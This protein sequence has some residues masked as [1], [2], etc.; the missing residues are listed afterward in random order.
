[1]TSLG[2]PKLLLDS[3]TC[4][5][6]GIHFVVL[7]PRRL[8][9]DSAV[10]FESVLCCEAKIVKPAHRLKVI[11]LNFQETIFRLLPLVLIDTNKL[12]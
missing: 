9:L 11:A 3:K 12:A 10:R 8:F 2:V 7:Q 6:S 5:G 4:L 1:M